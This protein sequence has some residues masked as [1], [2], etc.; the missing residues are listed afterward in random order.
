MVDE[1]G[2]L[3][4][5]FDDP[6]VLNEV[7]S[8]WARE[9]VYRELQ[10]RDHPRVMVDLEMIDYLSSLGIGA[11]VGLKKRVEAEDGRLV[12]IGVSTYL[13]EI[14]QGMGLLAILPIAHDSRAGMALLSSSPS[15]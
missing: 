1:A 10:K 7:P 2:V 4:V 14:L 5:R 3:I 15:A 11:L 8:L 6:T 9:A 12:L 13:C